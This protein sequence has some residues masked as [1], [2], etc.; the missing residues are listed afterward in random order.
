M[1][2][3]LKV[4]IYD[5]VKKILFVVFIICISFSCTYFSKYDGYKKTWDGIYYKL[6]T[7]GEETP[8]PEVGDY[9]T[10]DIAYK[11]IDDSVFFKGKRK[12]QLTKPEYKG[13]IDECF[14]LLSKGDRAEFIINAGKFFHTTLQ[15]NLPSFLEE[16]GD[17]KVDIAMLDIQTEKDYENQKRA[18]LKWIEDF[19]DYEK[20]LLSQYMKEQ[21]ISIKPTVSGLYFLT[22]KNGNGVRVRRG[23]TV[24]VDYEGRFLD[25][26][27]FDS[28]IKRKESF[29]FVYGTEWQVI[30]GIEEAIGMMHEGEKALV[31]IPSGLAF[32]E[33]GSTTGIIPPYTSLVFEVELKKIN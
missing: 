11:T 25:G 5:M 7:I 14:T 21:Q 23:D 28:T 2:L 26:K 10:I 12:L 9:I 6:L 15:N 20:E 18:F 8:T 29:Q 24:L 19:G 3:K 30:K 4:N 16:E 13:S 17:M 27:F 32:G 22:L 1:F 31:I 33:T